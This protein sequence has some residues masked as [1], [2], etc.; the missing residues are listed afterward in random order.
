MRDL[1]FL[2]QTKK[3]MFGFNRTQDYL[4]LEKQFVNQQ[5]F[6]ASQRDLAWVEHLKA[7]GGP[8]NLKPAGMRWDW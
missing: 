3:D 5:G 7:I 6:Y 8:D 2:L 1:F 4:I